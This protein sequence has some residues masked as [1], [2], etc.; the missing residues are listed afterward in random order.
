[1]MIG[2]LGWEKVDLINLLN[3]WRLCSLT[4]GKKI[5]IVHSEENSKIALRTEGTIS[6]SG[7]QA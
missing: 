3:I 7:Q 5:A 4:G 1:M 6:P 2:Q